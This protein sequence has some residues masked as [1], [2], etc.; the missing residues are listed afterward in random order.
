MYF[1]KQILFIPLNSTHSLFKKIH[2][3]KYNHIVHVKKKK[4]IG[5]CWTPIMYRTRLLRGP[6]ST[7]SLVV[8]VAVGLHFEACKSRSK[9]P[10]KTILSRQGIVF[11]G[12]LYYLS[13][14]VPVGACLV[15]CFV[16][17]LFLFSFFFFHFIIARTTATSG[18]PRRGEFCKKWNGLYI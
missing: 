17:V 8:V 7:Y 6:L 1:L 14:F 10:D 16:F 18:Q 13:A 5:Y 4:K 12:H 2:I 3:Y 15:F 9:S 11:G